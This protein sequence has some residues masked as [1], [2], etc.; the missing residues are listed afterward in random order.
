MDSILFGMDA[1]I[2]KNMTRILKKQGLNFTLKEGDGRQ[3]T[4]SGVTLT[5]EPRDGGDV[6][7]LK[8]DVV[9]A[10][11][12]TRPFTQGL[13]LETVG[14]TMTDHG[15]IQTDNHFKTNVDG[16][17]AIGDVI[18]GAMLAHKAEYEGVVLA[19][20]LAGQKCIDYDAIPGIVYTWPEAAG[21]VRQRRS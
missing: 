8:A 6:E 17:Y 9:L 13:G 16:I 5:I 10:G 2:S 14:V 3:K 15:F 11:R 4:K 19:E 18:G 1:E 12:G 20:I 21:L 7:T